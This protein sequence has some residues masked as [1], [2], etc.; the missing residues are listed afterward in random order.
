MAPATYRTIATTTQVPQQVIVQWGS[1]VL[2]EAKLGRKVA[3]IYAGNGFFVLGAC[4]QFFS[5]FLFCFV[6]W[7]T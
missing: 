6:F 2:Q 4:V 5:L 3:L 1:T 7:Y